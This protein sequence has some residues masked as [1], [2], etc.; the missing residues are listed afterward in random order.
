VVNQAVKNGTKYDLI[1]IDAYNG[2][3]LPDELATI[4]FFAGLKALTTPQG[5]MANFILDSD[6]DSDLATNIL[7]SR[8]HVFGDVWTMNVSKNPQK[9]FDNFIITAIQTTPDYSNF[10]KI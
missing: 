10:T 4:E 1:L 5:I 6:L 3:T 9:T 7:T 2:K 8:R